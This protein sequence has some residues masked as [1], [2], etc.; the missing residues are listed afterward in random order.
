[1]RRWGPHHTEWREFSFSRRSPVSV[2]AR[3]TRNL[4]SKQTP[5]IVE[6]PRAFNEEPLQAFERSATRASEAGFLRG[7]RLRRIMAVENPRGFRRNTSCLQK[8]F[9]TPKLQ[10]CFPKPKGGAW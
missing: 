10:R 8:N 7:Y 3:T 5:T 6:F 1:M 4:A 2:R 9:P